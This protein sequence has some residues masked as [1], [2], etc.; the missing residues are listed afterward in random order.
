MLILVRHGKSDWGADFGRDHE[1]PLAPRGIEAAGNIGSFLTRAG[2][3]PTAVL[4]STAV[5][6]H[7]TA[8]LAA[9]AGGWECGEIERHAA[10]YD[11]TVQDSL[12][13]LRAVPDAHET[14]AAFGHE[15]TWSNLASTLIGGGTLKMVTA[16]A[17]GIE[18]AP[19]SWSALEAGCGQLRF[20]MPPRL[21]A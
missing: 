13:V 8:E 11:A 16:A 9:R 1:R 17:V 5:R 12:D 18:I 20:F 15:P 7:T 2:L 14:V 3:A 6:A 4:S 19:A 21:L 10:L